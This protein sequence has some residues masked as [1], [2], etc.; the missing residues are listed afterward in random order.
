MGSKL[1]P[2]EKA[3]AAKAL[4]EELTGREATTKIKMRGLMCP[5]MRA[6]EHPAAPLLLEYARNGCPVDVGR[7]WTVEEL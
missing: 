5:R 7:N 6:L 2:V 1:S 3:Q 4:A